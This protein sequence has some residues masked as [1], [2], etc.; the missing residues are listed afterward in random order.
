RVAEL[1][2]DAQLLERA[3]WHAERTF[4]DDPRL[5]RPENSLLAEALVDS[6]GTEALAPIRA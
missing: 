3:R 1:P 2:R 4:A 5:E 6:Y